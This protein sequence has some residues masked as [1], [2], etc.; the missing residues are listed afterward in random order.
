MYTLNRQLAANS[1]A[2]VAALG[3]FLWLKSATGAIHVKTDTGESSVLSSGDFVTF[4]NVFTEF[5]IQD[6]SGAQNDLTFNISKGG[7]SGKYGTAVI[8]TPS[9]FSEMLDVNIP[10]FITTLLL[11]ANSKRAET[12]I[13]SGDSNQ[14]NTRIGSASVDLN[15]GV[16]LGPGSTLILNNTAA[17]YA[18]SISTALFTVSWSEYA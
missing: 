3:N 15:R 9:V 8:E 13:S 14:A 11:P 7:N 17:I 4:D 1:G 16:F 10:Q 18:I 6:L 2:N 12:I 5:F